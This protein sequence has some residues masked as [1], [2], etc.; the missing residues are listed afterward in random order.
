MSEQLEERLDRFARQVAALQEE[1]ADLRRLAASMAPQREPQVIWKPR[2]QPREPPLP[3]RPAVAPAAPT[4]APLTA[5]VGEAL[6]ARALALTGGAVT[7]L[8]V[9]LLFA[10]AVNRGWIGP[11]ERCAIGLA[12]SAAAFGGGLWLRRRYGETYSALAAVGAGIG[13]AYATLLAAAAMFHLLPDVAALAVAAGIA[14]IGVVTAIA[15]SAQIVAGLG[16]IGAMLVPVAVVF[17]AGLTVLGTSFVAIVLAATGIVALWRRWWRLIVAGFAVSVAQVA[18]LVWQAAP[19]AADATA[20]AAV[21]WLLYLAFAIG[22][23]LRAGPGLRS[24][25]ASLVLLAAVFAGTSAGHLF[26][27]LDEGLALLAIAATYGAAG[28]AFLARRSRRDLGSLL[29]AV[30]LAVGAVGLADL[31]SGNVLAIAWAAE[32]AVLAWLAPRVREPRFQL[33]SIAYLA[34]AGGHALALDA[35]L[36]HVF[37]AR[38]HPGTGAIG[39]AATAIAAAICALYARDLG[40]EE[41]AAAG[42]FLHLEP[43]F[44]RLRASQAVLR[45]AFLWTAGVFATYA[46]SLGLLELFQLGGGFDWGQLPV[47]T[48]WAL[49]AAALLTVGA[50]RRSRRLCVGGGV[51]LA[52]TLAKV[53]LY[54]LNWLRDPIDSYVALAAGAVVLLG[55]YLHGRQREGSGAGGASV[56]SVLAGAAL[57]VI[58]VT[59]LLRGVP[60]GAALLGLAACYG[61]LGASVFA[62]RDLSTWLWATGLWIALGAWSDL[63]GG[64]PLIVAWA[65][66]GAALAWLASRRGEH[67]F[68]LAAAATIALAL[69]RTIIV[70]APPR[71]LFVA[72]AHPGGGVFALAAVTLATAAHAFF[73]RTAPEREKRAGR[74]A[75]LSFELDRESVRS[76]PWVAGILGV[77]AVSLAIL[78]LFEWGGTGSV[79]LDFQHGHTAVSALWGVLGL[80]ALYLGLARR[81]RGLR[82]A[83]FAIFGVSLGK[84]F[85]YDLSALSSITRALSFLAVGAVLLLGGFFYQ[86][87]S[88]QL[89]ERH[90]LPG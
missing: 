19:G 66:T 72:G 62:R 35:P 64:T 82:L 74:G 20:L 16:L 17:D 31:F 3:Q 63:L 41:P 85:L 14:S 18:A 25:S 61:L 60:E 90:P 8:G 71:D 78:Q 79:H 7:L 10:L 89:D 21:F 12:A 73:A 24:L 27:G 42:V 26:D 23:Q 39:V 22:C 5:G 65:A 43:L 88:S 38:N 9:V 47:S 49:E 34:L 40:A 80:G 15:W 50:R 51:V 81:R 83:G 58:A 70:V 52:A 57:L 6:G 45:E 55:G 75:R 37:V 4:R 59:G 56:T 68:R 77:D 36:S 87:L 86:R 28:A 48:L 76:A 46:A 67:R 2:D 30:G 32:A 53:F 29:W 11:W 13:G 1:L 84:I 33:G 44:A 54:D 69:L